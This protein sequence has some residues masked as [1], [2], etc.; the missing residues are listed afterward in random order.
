M[1]P[2]SILYPSIAMALLTLALLVYMG[3]SRAGAVRRG[4]V[5]PRFYRSYREGEQPEALHLL[6]RHVQNHFEVPPLF[7]VV[8]L[9]TYVTGLVDGLAVGLS[10]AFFGLRCLH[11][12]VHLGGN[13]VP[14]RFAVFGL[15]VLALAGLWVHLW[16]GLTS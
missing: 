16:W 13:R 15:S 12:M 5:N 1:D 11:T 8:V 14:R 6:G 9:A 7:H 4:E 3:L 10:W 2:S